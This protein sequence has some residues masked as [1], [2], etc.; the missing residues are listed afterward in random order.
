MFGVFGLLDMFGVYGLIFAF[1]ETIGIP[2]DFWVWDA[3]LLCG[4]NLINLLK[5]IS[6]VTYFM[7]MN[8]SFKYGLFNGQET[9]S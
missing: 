9:L 4:L 5:F 2:L 3:S 6:N 7:A 1:V 8:F